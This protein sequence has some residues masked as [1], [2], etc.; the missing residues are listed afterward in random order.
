MGPVR[1][2]ILLLL[3]L[4]GACSLRAALDTLTPEKDRAFA[5]EMV[6]RLRG[7]DRAWLERHFDPELWAKS[8][9]QLAGVP[10]L[11]PS[12]AGKTE[13]IGFHLSSSLANG[14]SVRS[15]Q[16]TLVTQ[17]GGRWT[18]TSF[19]TYS[20]GGPDKVVQWSVVPHSSPPPEVVMIETWDAALPWFR[21]G[22][23]VCLLAIGGLVFWLVRR[24]RRKRD[25]SPPA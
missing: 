23:A 7:G 8:G 24:S 22:M 21:G 5:G 13:I 10:A 17:G 3:L 9:G 25:R 1:H 14:R 6:T 12:E 20:A 2:F 4:L 16:F 11:F 19:Q 15:K 18:V